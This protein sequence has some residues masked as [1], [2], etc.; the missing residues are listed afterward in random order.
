VTL[1][2]LRTMIINFLGAP[3]MGKK[4][5]AV[6]GLAVLAVFAVPAAA[7]AA[8]YVPASDVVVSGATA[9]GSTATVTFESGFTPGENVSFAV[10]GEGSATLAVFKSAT[11]TLTKTATSAGAATVAVTLPANATGTYTTTAT[12]LSS[13]TVGTASL[14]VA[15]ADSGTAAKSGLAET[16]YNAP[17]LL[18]WA[19]AGALI[20]G[21][22]LVVVLTIVRRQR[23]TA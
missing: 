22:A 5:L 12:G 1:F 8:G 3:H 16:G 19:A 6:I 15:A 7:N 9:P 4:T 17:M 20:L 2:G 14:T 23:A 18:I 11:V 10:S 13:G 21:L